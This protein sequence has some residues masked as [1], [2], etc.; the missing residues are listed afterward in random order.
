MRRAERRQRLESGRRCRLA[1]RRLRRSAV[2][3]A[4]PAH[5]QTISPRHGDR[6]VEAWR[7]RRCRRAGQEVAPQSTAVPMR[8]PIRRSRRLLESRRSDVFVRSLALALPLAV[9][10]RGQREHRMRTGRRACRQMRRL[11]GE[12][13]TG[14]D[15]DGAD[16][17]AALTAERGRR[18]VRGQGR[19]C[20]APTPTQHVDREEGCLAISRVQTDRCTHTS[21]KRRST[22]AVL[23]SPATT[24]S[25]R[26]M[27]PDRPRSTGSSSARAAHAPPMPTRRRQTG[28][29]RNRC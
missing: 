3:S 19:G 27:S 10:D 16:A 24:R 21:S 4:S 6:L 13:P 15:V 22:D 1:D 18:V 20:V 25:R 28:R 14:D 11:A 12:A 5:R 2:T 7:Q 9:V 29:T 8:A 23:T 17:V 26:P